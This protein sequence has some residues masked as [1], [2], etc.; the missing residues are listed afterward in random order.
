[1]SIQPT[2]AQAFN[3]AD[4]SAR[5]R[6]VYDALADGNKTDHEIAAFGAGTLLQSVCGARNR[7][8]EMGLVE[9]TSLT[10]PSPGGFD[11]IIWRL[12]G[13][14]MPLPIEQ[15]IEAD[16]RRGEPEQQKLGLG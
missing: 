1:M 5:Q 8:V 9:K 13:R 12:T 11:C 2:S 14:P 16:V 7:L 3:S 15:Y 6:S 4:L 10:R